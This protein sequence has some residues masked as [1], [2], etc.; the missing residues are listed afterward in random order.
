MHNKVV[1]GQGH[2]TT[3]FGVQEVKVQDHM[4]LEIDLEVWHRHYSQSSWVE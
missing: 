3:N 2:E 4:R 1:D